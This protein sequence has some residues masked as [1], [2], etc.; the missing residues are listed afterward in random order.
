MKLIVPLL[1][2][3]SAV[4]FVLNREG[5]KDQL[6]DGNPPPTETPTLIPSQTPTETQVPT[7][8][9]FP[10]MTLVPLAGSTQSQG[11]GL[12]TIC[13]GLIVLLIMGTLVFLFIRIKRVVQ[14]PAVTEE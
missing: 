9:V 1:L 14:H 2:L 3:L 6:L 5:G 11:G 13:W 7:L 12:P 10:T 4:L 8:A